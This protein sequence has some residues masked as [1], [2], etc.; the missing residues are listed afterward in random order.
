MN[1]IN[2]WVFNCQNRR[3]IWS[4]GF[5]DSLALGP[6]IGPPPDDSYAFA[7]FDMGDGTF[8]LQ[9]TGGGGM[10]DIYPTATNTF[11]SDYQVITSTVSG[12]IKDITDRAKFKVV[13]IGD[14]YVALYYPAFDEYLTV[15]PGDGSTLQVWSRQLGQAAR[16]TVVG[17]D[18]D[19]IFDLMQ[20]GKNA[21]G[22]VFGPV[23]L[24]GRDLSGTNL[25]QCDLRNVTSLIGC[26]LNAAG[27]QQA[28]LA[29]LH[30]GGLQISGAIC[31]GADFTGCDFTSFMPGTP[32]PVLA[33]ANLT[34]AV[35]PGSLAGAN[36]AGAV[37]AEANLTGAD[38]SGP[39]TDLAGANFSGEGVSYFT[40]AYRGG[41]IGTYDLADPADRVIAYDYAGTRHL[42][43]LVCYRPG[44]RTIYI[45]KK[46]S[47]TNSPNAF[48]PVYHQSGIGDYDLTSPADRVIA[49]DYAGSGYPNYLVCYRPGR[50]AIFIVE[51][52]S[53][54]DSPDAFKAVYSQG[55]PGGSGL[56]GGIGGYD[57]ADPADQI[58]AYDYEDKGNLN[59][60]VCYRPGT[61]MIRILKRISDQN[62]PNAFTPVYHQSGIGTYNLA[63]PADRIIAYDFA[64]TGHLN[65][66]VCYRP[67]TGLLWV[68]KKVSDA[69]SPDAFTPLYK[70]D[71]TWIG[72]NGGYTLADP[73]A[74]VIAYDHQGTGHVA[75]LVCYRPGSIT[76]RSWVQQ[77]VSQDGPFQVAYSGGGIGDLGGY[78]DLTASADR[79]IA[80]DY[81]SSGQLD[82]LVCYRPGIGMISI[83]RHQAAKPA[84]LT[85]A[86]LGQADL[87]G[88]KLAGVNLSGL[89]LTGANLSGAHLPGANLSGTQMP[90]AKLGGAD[91]TGAVLAGTDFTGTDLTQ[92]VFSFPLTRSTDPDHPTIFAG[93][94]LPYA[95]IKLDW[96][97]LDLTGTTVIGLPTD[98]T[99]LVAIGMR[100]P[101]GSFKNFILDGAK[102][103]DSTLD[104]AD[105]TG[106]KLR[107]KASFAGA[108]LPGAFFIG[109]VLDQANF[110]GATLGGVKLT[111][112]ADFSYAF[113]SNCDF[114]QAGLY[115]VIFSGATLIS[116]NV[117]AD[118]TN[119][120]EADF[121]DAYLPNADFTGASLQG[122]KFDGA[123]MVECILTSA[124]L[125]PAR[126]GAIPSSLSAACLQ[127]AVL[128]GTK[129]AGASFANAA[130]TDVRGTIMQQY[131]DED[132]SLTPM[133]PMTY[134]AGS[135][136]AANSLSDTTVCPNNSTYKAN[137]DRGL[138]IA[139]MMTAPNPPTQWTPRNKLGERQRMG[140]YRY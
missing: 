127:A 27:L 96:S 57:L 33:G 49:Y 56:G 7:V 119:L 59:Y 121:S 124:D 52:V 68:L 62:S 101:E 111:E 76:G 90:G 140:T 8:V 94:T 34:G 48:T 75:D 122:A 86:K 54:T 5:W 95:V 60:L 17:L 18:H 98:L 22:M 92:V 129:L 28:R 85:R 64:G 88:A 80:F 30:L 77:R 82:S 72:G 61:G 42:D 45:L 106:A 136:P 123:F 32:A 9:I 2:R 103:D 133:E 117:L 44:H 130:I 115:A 125:T 78:Y 135:F 40:P 116:G 38:L 73:A 50:G 39:A 132:G 11:L 13:P 113:L 89:Q 138:T 47:D 87:S 21:Q 66:L 91:L 58:I 12:W 55:D 112:A 43:H 10:P 120:Q 104:R 24:A 118:G 51:K 15:S 37:L 31:Q 19:S 83:M 105:F 25:A 131:Y 128:L 4:G 100:R 99:G 114:T 110:S 74:Q 3:M 65:Y 63:D 16:F 84:T 139:Q 53:D 35:V 93:C 81:A 70:Q 23:S 26:K 108:R 1:L 29:G 46:V 137:V 126:E 36:L 41:G 6:A 71:A 97:C 102:F 20:V 134:K 69:D 107:G 67:G 109:A 79:V 14:G